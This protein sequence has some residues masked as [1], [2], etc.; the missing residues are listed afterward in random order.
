MVRDI[1]RTRKSLVTF[2]LGAAVG[3]SLVTGCGAIPPK[4]TLDICVN[5]EDGMSRFKSVLEEF[6]DQNG[7]T[8]VDDSQNTKKL[9]ELANKEEGIRPLSGS[10]SFSVLDGEESRIIASNT[11]LVEHQLLFVIFYGELSEYEELLSMLRS[12]WQVKE[13]PYRN[14]ALPDSTCGGTTS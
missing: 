9:I 6:S 11:G 8:F 5:D 14:G 12:N 1:G 13:V 3:L 2:F 7:F 10:K 4:V